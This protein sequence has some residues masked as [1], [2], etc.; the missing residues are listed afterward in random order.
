MLSCR[1]SGTVVLCLWCGGGDVPLRGDN[2]CISPHVAYCS[3]LCIGTPRVM[4]VLLEVRFHRLN[5]VPIMSML[6]RN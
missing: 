5:D 6:S 2:A 1:E 3:S 4:L